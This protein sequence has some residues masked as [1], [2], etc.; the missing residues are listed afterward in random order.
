[1]IIITNLM[2]TAC[3]AA[4]AAPRCWMKFKPAVS[5][6]CGEKNEDGH[7]SKRQRIVLSL[8][9]IFLSD[10]CILYS[11]KVISYFGA[12]MHLWGRGKQMEKFQRALLCSRERLFWICARS[13]LWSVINWPFLRRPNQKHIICQRKTYKLTCGRK[14]TQNSQFICKRCLK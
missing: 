8:G 11:R 14:I 5:F 9:K 7:I 3:S 4:M 1:M 13:S 12:D 6:W 10:G 2:P